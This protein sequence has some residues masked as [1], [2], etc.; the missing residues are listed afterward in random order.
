MS[1]LIVSY[2]KEVVRVLNFIDLVLFG[3]GAGKNQ[4]KDRVVPSP[5]LDQIRFLQT[6]LHDYEI[7]KDCNYLSRKRLVGRHWETLSSV[8]DW[9]NLIKISIT[10]S[11]VSL[12]EIMN[13]ED[14]YSLFIEKILNGEGNE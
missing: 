4:L 3:I 1:L 13:N 10:G 7:Y 12:F 9:L 8:K 11:K 5:T 14:L 6:F 2:H